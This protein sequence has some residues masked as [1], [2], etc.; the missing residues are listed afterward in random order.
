MGEAGIQQK[1]IQAVLA[2]LKQEIEDAKAAKQAQPKIIKN[3]YIVART[4][5]PAGTKLTETPMMV[6]EAPDDVAWNSVI[7]EIKNAANVGNNDCKKLKKDP[8]KSIFDTLDRCPAKYLK[9]FQIRVVT[10]EMP[11]VLETDN[12]IA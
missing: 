1:E 3:K 7:D 2:K 9:Q 11:Q 6:V 8:L 12:S 5:L 10:K 4:D